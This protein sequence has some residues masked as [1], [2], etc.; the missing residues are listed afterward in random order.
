MHLSKMMN[1]ASH[2]GNSHKEE[3]MKK[4]DHMLSE[5]GDELIEMGIEKVKKQMWI[6]MHEAVNGPHFDEETAHE[7]VEMMENED[8]SKGPKWSAREAE[9]LAKQFNIDTRSEDF[10]EWDWFVALNMC[11]SDYCEVIEKLT[12]NMDPMAFV[13]LAK[14]WLCDKDISEGKMWNYY[15]HIMC[16][17][18]KDDKHSMHRMNRM[19]RMHRDEMY[20]MY[21]MDRR[22]RDSKGRFTSNRMNRQGSGMNRGRDHGYSTGSNN[23]MDYGQSSDYMYG[24]EDMHRG[25]SSMSSSNRMDMGYD[26]KGMYDEYK[27]MDDER[28]GRPRGRR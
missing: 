11:Y 14:A 4:M 20:G 8:G 16:D 22:H 5:Y 23:R 13:C 9:M 17:D 2:T 10:N 1:K 27:M 3:M 12:G 6:C 26:H 15:V 18:D 7:A 21:D 25:N 19:H 24:M 28:R